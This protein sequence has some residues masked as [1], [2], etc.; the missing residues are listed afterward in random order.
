MKRWAWGK[1]ALIGIMAWMMAIPLGGCVYVVVGGVGALG[2]Y[3]ASPDTVVGAIE[4]KDPGQVWRASYEV[5]S[6]MGMIEEENQP[7]GIL[8]AKLQNTKVTVAIAPAGYSG[9]K[10]SVKARRGMFPKIRIAQDAYMKIVN[11]L[12]GGR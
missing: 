4:S 5:L 11:R 3:V 2:G 9:S 10:I 7:E 6:F 12:E 1:K 8:I